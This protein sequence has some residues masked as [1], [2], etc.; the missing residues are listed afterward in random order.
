MEMEYWRIACEN[1]DEHVTL[2]AQAE[3]APLFVQPDIFAAI[4]VEYAVDHDG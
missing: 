3:E 4:A 1:A 2:A